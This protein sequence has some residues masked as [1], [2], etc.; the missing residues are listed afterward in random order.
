MDAVGSEMSF[1]VTSVGL[2]D[3]ADLGGCS[4]AALRGTGGDGLFYRFAA[5]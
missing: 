5:N 1:F 4:Q 2:G 3:G